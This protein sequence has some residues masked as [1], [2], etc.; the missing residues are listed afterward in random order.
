MLS[1]TLYHVPFALIGLVTVICRVKTDYQEE[2]EA[3]KRTQELQKVLSSSLG[4][5]TFHF[6]D[7][8]FVLSLQDSQPKH[9]CPKKEEL[10]ET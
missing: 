10:T 4:I 3:L 8:P 6:V 1:V 7:I 5:V 9:N 2:V